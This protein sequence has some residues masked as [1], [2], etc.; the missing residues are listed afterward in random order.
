[1]DIHNDLHT[2]QLHY[3]KTPNVK[4]SSDNG[5][6]TNGQ[7]DSVEISN[8]E[9]ERARQVREKLRSKAEARRRHFDEDV[10][11]IEP[12]LLH[13]FFSMLSSGKNGKS[14]SNDDSSDNGASTESHSFTG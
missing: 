6:E 10:R 9:L 8:D 5:I 13:R 12:S 14:D 3:L 7:R 4:H 1:M 2:E 11:L